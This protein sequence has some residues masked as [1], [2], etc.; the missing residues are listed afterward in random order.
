MKKTFTKVFSAVLV[1][2]TM[3]A[4]LT[5]EAQQTTLAS[6]NTDKKADAKAD[7]TI[8]TTTTMLKGQTMS[9]R[10][11]SLAVVQIPR[12][13]CQQRPALTSL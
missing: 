13:R 11:P 1:S 2:A 6:A 10:L 4:G 7:S 8:T 5:A 12:F 3:L 9:T